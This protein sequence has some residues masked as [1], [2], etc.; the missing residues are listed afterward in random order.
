M[1]EYTYEP[2]NFKLNII[3]DLLSRVTLFSYDC[4]F[5]S[6]FCEILTRGQYNWGLKPLNFLYSHYDI[7]DLKVTW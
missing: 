6:D 5:Y 7:V 3:K 1:R 4:D 2:S